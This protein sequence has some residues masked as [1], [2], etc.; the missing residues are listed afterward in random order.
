MNY[1]FL[2]SIILLIG[3]VVAPLHCS[4]NK[5][6]SF[7]PK[8]GPLLV[9]TGPAGTD[10]FMDNRIQTLCDYFSAHTP[11]I[12]IS[13]ILT[14]N[15]YAELPRSIEKDYPE[16]TNKVISL[17]SEEESVAVILLLPGKDDTILI[18]NGIRGKTSPAWLLK[19][20]SNALSVSGKSWNLEDYVMPLYRIGWKGENDLLACYLHAEIPAIILESET[21]LTPVLSQIAQSLSTGIPDTNDNHYLAYKL[22][23]SLVIIGENILVLIMI[24][25]SAIILMFL[26]IFSFMF[27]KKS[28]QHFRDLFHVWWLPF[29]YLIVNVLA[30]YGGQLLSFSLFYFRFGNNESW[31][32]IPGIA[33]AAKLSIAW[34]FITIVFSLNHLIRFP[35]DSFIYGYI[36]SVVCML[37][38][39]VFSSLDFSLSILFLT[40]YVISFFAYH[41][42]HP[43]AQVIGIVALGL[44]FLPYVQA[45]VSGGSMSIAPLYTGSDFWNFRI[46][47]FFMPFQLM[48][49][50]LFHTLKLYTH[51]TKIFVPAN[52]FIV[53][54]FTL[55]MLV[56]AL[57]S[58]AWSEKR[59]LE[60]HIIQTVDADGNHLETTTP[61]KLS[62]LVVESDASVAS[63]PT[64]TVSPE[65]IIKITASSQL[66]LERQL[67]SV[68]IQPA[69]PVRKLEVDVKCDSGI[70]VYDA[71]ILFALK[72][73]GQDAV[74][75]SDVNPANPWIISFSSSIESPLQ[76]T[77]RAWTRDNPWGLIVR[78]Q[79]M[80]T[81]YLLEVIRK[82][83]IP[84]P[85]NAHKKANP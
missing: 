46:A 27:G 38:I 39:F 85:A 30:L 1:R 63:N 56:A 2:S 37:N 6:W 17:I 42:S 33:F 12:R 22:K 77:V 78:N 3:L 76:I 59:P 69:I 24:I 21:D 44:P 60:T 83:E 65:A 34:F 47:L 26:I 18:R 32:L 52:L 9:V 66:L 51:R 58:P 11:L 7:G 80:K 13:I 55:I 41:T 67:V 8:T 19:N 53:F 45:L 25:A 64:L 43:V 4:E 72:N 5:I 14:E 70:A 61:V 74:F 16:G 68:S 49:T 73:S 50:R 40:V 20:V 79:D 29:L 35:D 28:E 36:A 84:I 48:F 23:D 71:S 82:I 75:V 54:F 81:D 10:S 62:N 57:F 31:S 15:D